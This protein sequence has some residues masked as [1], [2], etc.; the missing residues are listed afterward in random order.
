[1]GVGGAIKQGF[2]DA[3]SGQGSGVDFAQKGAKFMGDPF[4]A[5]GSLMEGIS[6]GAPAP[7]YIGGSPE[8]LA[9]RQA[10]LSGQAQAS[11]GTGMAQQ[12]QGVGMLGQAGDQSRADRS[13]AYGMFNQGMGLGSGGIDRQNAQ[14]NSLLAQAQFEGP[15]QAQAQMQQGLDQT[16]RAMLGQAAQTRGGNQAA[17]MRNAQSA[18]SQMALQTNQQAAI[19]RAQE[20]QQRQQNILGAQQ[21]AAGSYGQQA[22]LGYGLA[23][24]GLGAAQQSTGQLG[25]F[26]ANVSQAGLGQQ[27]VGLGAMGILTDQDKAQME[28][29]RANRSAEKT[30]RNPL[31]IGGQILGGIFGG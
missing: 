23:G 22:G 20:A 28:A 5:G 2:G 18:G 17:A 27:N 26:G 15:S 12:Q 3:F 13:N 25:Q 4:G 6:G 24:Q 11:F 1:M 30:A 21:F 8:E 16:Q 29:E 9:R 7:S 10:M 14:L 31:G 19:L